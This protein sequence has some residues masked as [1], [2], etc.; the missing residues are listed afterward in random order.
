MCGGVLI[1]NEF[2]KNLIK[3]TSVLM[4]ISGGAALLVGAT[5]A[6]TAPVIENNNVEKEKKMLSE[7][8]GDDAD[9]YIEWSKDSTSSDEKEKGEYLSSLT[10][11][12]VTKVWTAKK[13]EKT[14]GYITRFY[15][16]NGYGDVDMLLGVSIDGKM[17]NLCVIS[18]TMSYKSKLESGY[19]DKYNDSN[20][21]ESAVNDVKCGATFAAN[22]IKKGVEESIEVVTMKKSVSLVSLSFKYERSI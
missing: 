1:M 10:L 8:Y 2:V 16:K 20:N 13:G 6:L 9:T 18:D 7:V 22:L 5:N 3:T 19:I 14:I 21:K 17:G 15:G 4:I 12:Y 11:S